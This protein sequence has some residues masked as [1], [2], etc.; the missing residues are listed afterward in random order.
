MRTRVFPWSLPTL[1]AHALSLVYH[2]NDTCPGLLPLRQRR[3]QLLT[4]GQMQGG[5]SN[6]PPLSWPPLAATAQAGTATVAHVRCSRRE[7]CGDAAAPG[8]GPL[9]LLWQPKATS[10][11]AAAGVRCSRR[12]LCG[13]VVATSRSNW[14]ALAL[15]SCRSCGRDVCVPAC[16]CQGGVRLLGP[17]GVHHA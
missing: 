17:G 8:V 11:A 2:H 1:T 14:P 6:Q 12:E 4:E 16:T 7:L 10:G 3:L 15:L 13:G 5:P 9:L